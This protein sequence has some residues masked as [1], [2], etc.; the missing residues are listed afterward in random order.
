MTTVFNLQKKQLAILIST[1]CLTMSSAF[2]SNCEGNTVGNLT[3]LDINTLETCALGAGE[4][5]VITPHGMLSRD[6]EY[7]GS[8][9]VLV[10][11]AVS[12]GAINNQ[13]VIERQGSG[14]LL[15]NGTSVTGITNA[16]NARITTDDTGILILGAT[17][18]GQLSN[19]GTINARTGGIKV[20]GSVIQKGIGN[21]G[22]IDTNEGSGID[23]LNGSTIHGGITNGLNGAISAG[24]AGILVTESTVNGGITN[25][26]TIDGGEGGAIQL[27]YRSIV[28]GNVL[29]SGKLH[30]RDTAAL[31]LDGAVINGQLINSGT[32]SGVNDDAI[33]ISN[34]SITQ[35]IIN[36][37]SGRILSQYS[38][39]NIY[40]SEIGGITNAGLIDGAEGGMGSW[41][42]LLT[43]TTRPSIFHA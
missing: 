30:S 32:I 12:A 25:A 40:G 4:S 10:T 29:N 41:G 42:M 38:G 21:T 18:N 28:N 14:I 13:G 19:A 15:D 2:A 34:A 33:Y 27:G 37:A 43:L 35:G 20:S 1:A 31:G 39:I 17:I 9:G 8:I 3:T 16:G 26:G 11:N 7:G 6:D 36:T 5:I 24:A 23:I 22:V